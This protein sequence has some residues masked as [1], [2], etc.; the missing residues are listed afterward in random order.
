MRNTIFPPKEKNANNKAHDGDV[1]ANTHEKK[2]ELS[3]DSTRFSSEDP[4][5]EKDATLK[6]LPY[7]SKGF[8]ENIKEESLSPDEKS[9]SNENIKGKNIISTNDVDGSDD[10]EL[11]PEMEENDDSD[12]DDKTKT[13]RKKHKK[14]TRSIFEIYQKVEVIVPH[15]SSNKS[16]SRDASST[17][18]SATASP[19]TC[20]W[21]RSASVE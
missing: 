16:S 19:R 1:A 18:A 3:G 6:D 12:D 11:D 20:K 8:V 9:D 2:K 5:N 21:D 15:Q 17:A 14:K 7:T 4:N 10:D 13:M